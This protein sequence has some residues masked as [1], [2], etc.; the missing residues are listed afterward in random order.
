MKLRFS[1][2]IGVVLIVV[3]IAMTVILYSGHRSPSSDVQGF[4]IEEIPA[5][6]SEDRPG[7]P[8]PGAR[9]I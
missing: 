8:T 9:P 3:G 6:P 1:D 7:F 4:T 2:L 5:P